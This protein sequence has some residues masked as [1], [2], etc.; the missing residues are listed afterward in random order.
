MNGVENLSEDLPGYVD[1]L[2]QNKTFRKY[3]DRYDITEKLN[4]QADQLPNRLGDAA[5]TLQDV[6]V[7]VFDRFVQLFAILVIT[8]FLLMEGPQILEFGYAQLPDERER[9]CV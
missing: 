3:D 5:G 4:E 6:T 9:A 2:R 1:D 7:G 8:F